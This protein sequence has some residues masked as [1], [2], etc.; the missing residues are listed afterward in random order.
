[1]LEEVEFLVN[2]G[3]GTGSIIRGLHKH[4]PNAI[5]YPKNVYNAI[6]IFWRN[7]KMVKTDAAETYEKLMRRQHE[8]HGWFIEVRLEGEN[9]HLTG[10]FWMKLSQIDL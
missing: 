5:I 9:N 7:Q 2:I 8:E 4:F 10:L 1:M 6:C 3:C